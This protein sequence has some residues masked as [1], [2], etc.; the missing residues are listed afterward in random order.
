MKTINP[1][2]LNGIERE[3]SPEKDSS[4]YDLRLTTRVFVID[5]NMNI[6]LVRHLQDDMF[7]PPGG[8]VEEGETVFEASVR[9][10]VEEL[11]VT[12]NPV[13]DLGILEQY[14][15]KW[16][17]KFI[18]HH[19][20]AT[21]DKQEIKIDYEDYDTNLERVWMSIEEYRTLLIDYTENK[22]PDDTWAKAILYFLNILVNKL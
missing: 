16:M 11:G 18:I 22:K 9:E 5:S 10:V 3:Y 2:T 4:E 13:E 14:H 6:G 1:N 17:K 15:E 7:F 8:G 19:V 20:Y 12:C 21:T